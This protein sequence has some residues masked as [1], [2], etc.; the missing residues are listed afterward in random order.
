MV[1]E[2]RGPQTRG[3][4]KS[5][6][7]L[8]Y[9]RLLIRSPEDVVDEFVASGIEPGEAT[10]VVNLGIQRRYE[11]RSSRARRAWITGVVVFTTSLGVSILTFVSAHRVGGGMYVVFYGAVFAGLAEMLRAWTI[12]PS[13][14]TYLEQI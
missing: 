12:T 5:L 11:M 9:S 8:A 13:P 10:R 2:R 7:S 6:P 1:I 14:P 4:L 3:S